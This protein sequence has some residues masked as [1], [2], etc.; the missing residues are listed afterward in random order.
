MKLRVIF[1]FLSFTED[2]QVIKKI[3]K[4]L[5]DR[6]PPRAEAPSSTIHIDYPARPARPGATNLSVVG[7]GDATH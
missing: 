6:P 4:H 5:G 7:L 2:E 3:L 1:F